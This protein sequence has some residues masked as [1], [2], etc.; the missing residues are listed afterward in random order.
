L[1]TSARAVTSSMSR[2]MASTGRGRWARLLSTYATARPLQP[3]EHRRLQAHQRRV[4]HRRLEADRRVEATQLR[5]PRDGAAQGRTQAPPA[6]G[7][8]VQLADAWWRARPRTCSTLT[9][10]TPA[11]CGQSWF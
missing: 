5:R 4:R 9:L 11:S 8:S 2:T 10:M 6:D 1:T 7:A 3:R